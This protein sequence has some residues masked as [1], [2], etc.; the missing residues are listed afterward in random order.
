MSIIFLV[1][2]PLLFGFAAYGLS[3]LLT[4]RSIALAHRGGLLAHPNERSSHTEPTP[5]VGGIG[6]IVPVL[7]LFAAYQLLAEPIQRM[8]HFTDFDRVPWVPFAGFMVSVALAF[9]L[10]LW[11]DRGNPP[12]LV[13]LAGQF[14][15]AAIPPAA[16]L[17][18]REITIPYAGTIALPF[19]VGA[20]I[21]FVWIVGLMNA[22][23][24]M[25]GIDGLAGRFAQAFALALLVIGI[26][27]SWCQEFAVLGAVLYGSAAGFL[28][29]NLPRAKT[30]LGDCGS[31]PLGALAA[32]AVL[33]LI[34]N[35]LHFTP[36]VFDPFLGGVILISPFLFDAA[37]T[38]VRRTL[39]GENLL[40]AHREHLYQRFLIARGENHAETLRYVEFF[41]WGAA[42]A[43]VLYIRFS[44]PADNG[45][46]SFLLIA[47]VVLL[48]AYALRARAAERR[49]ATLS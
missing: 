40:R 48:A 37:Y 7:L 22:V 30:F 35:D 47:T 17:V 14:L 23:N 27:R 24:F 21:A 12:A 16:G 6:M 2:P 11:D 42:I 46:R 32:G 19:A 18:V 26:N 4:E 13:K 1:L 41:L 49:S 36:P 5:R 9:A 8:Q 33:L 25:D 3:L 44:T 43:G 39:R 15:I 34:N 28:R 45:F 10:G 20:A 31:Q 29:W 38:L